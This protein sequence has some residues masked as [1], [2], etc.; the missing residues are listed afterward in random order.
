MFIY[1]Y[2]YLCAYLIRII[3]TKINQADYEM[4][5][6]MGIIIDF[7]TCEEN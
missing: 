3:Q 5:H 6:S 7:S 2:V 4:L 1:V